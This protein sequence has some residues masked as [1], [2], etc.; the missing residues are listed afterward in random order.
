[1]TMP[2]MPTIYD[3]HSLPFA[4]IW[5]ADTEYYPGTGLAN[6][7]VHG[8]PVTALCLVAVEMRSGR[9][10][11]LWQD[12][13]GR[14]P[15]YRL[16]AEG[17]FIT[18][19]LAADFGFHLALGWGAPACALD[20]LIEFRHFMNDGAVTRDDRPKGFYSLAGA[21]RCFGEDE[22]DVTHKD[23]M[24]DRILQGPP[25]S[26]TEK[27]AIIGYCHDDVSGLAQ[28][29]RHLVPTIRSLPHAL[30]RSRVQWAIAKQEARGVP[31][32]LS[33]LAPVRRHWVGMRRD[34][35][36]EL[37][38]FGCYEFDAAGAP[39]WRKEAFADYL[40]RN[41]MAWPRLPS[42]AYDE[43][44]ETFRE[45]EGRYPQ[46]GQLRELRYSLSKLKLSD[47]AV[48]AD[49]RNRTPLW[50]YGTKTGRCAPSTTAYIFGPAK[51]VRHFIGPPPGQALVHRDYKQQEVR[52]AAIQS[53]D[54]NL[55]QACEGDVYLG[56]AQQLGF[57]SPSMNAYEL[58]A[59]RTMFKT[60]VLGVQYGLGARGL[61]M[62]LGVSLYEAREILARVHA[63]FWRFEDYVRGVLD[64][65]GLDL[66]VS[67]PLG[68]V[69]QTPSAIRPT[70]VRNYPMQ[71]SGSEILHVLCVLAE[72]RGIEIVAPVHDAFL[73]EGPAAELEDLSRAL[74]QLMGD[75]AA[76]VL[77]GYRLPTDCQLVRPGEH[78]CDERGA[79]M[80]STV[81]R[82]V[83]KL[84]RETA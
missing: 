60:V 41:R 39:H 74:D 24:V 76:V 13:L 73:A 33:A 5:I 18:Y 43:K 61:G 66:E 64:H 59:V 30:L 48:G 17:L 72:R 83:A 68:W 16:D 11:R 7:G 29:V 69:M 19:G 12:E 50:A 15:P 49:G 53:G 84:E 9:L 79:A 63:T 70:I 54:A 28:V 26:E 77:R 55:L 62:R 6:G 58:K 14:F 37:D 23:E 46:I 65:A 56:M 20:A 42:G 8:D 71:S 10:V 40:Q 45:M 35:V 34:L 51:W 47:L 82:L 2:T 3:W 67:T 75:A 57:V 36:C 52:I 32:N 44:D 21:L 78:F 22:L 80:W 25:F 1:M 4:E 31:I 27:Q 38:Q 81:S